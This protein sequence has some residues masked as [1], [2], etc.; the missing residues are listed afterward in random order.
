VKK[1]EE[2]L[3]S[4]SD[5]PSSILNILQERTHSFAQNTVQVTVYE[6]VPQSIEEAVR[7]SF[8]A[9]FCFAHSFNPPT[10]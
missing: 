2:S 1:A 6:F 3:T 8:V 7:F 10:S 4:E 9:L 5:R